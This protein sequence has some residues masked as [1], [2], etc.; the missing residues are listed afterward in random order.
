MKIN[1]DHTQYIRHS[2]RNKVRKLTP[3]LELYPLSNSPL[4]G[5]QRG[6][7]GTF[8]AEIFLRPLS[9]ENAV[10]SLLNSLTFT[11]PL[12]TSKSQYSTLRSLEGGNGDK[13]RKLHA[14]MMAVPTASVV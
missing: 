6:C 3:L 1:S 13:S 5:R 12:Q 9:A 10:S 8:K 7:F 4:P 2:A 14:D 11:H